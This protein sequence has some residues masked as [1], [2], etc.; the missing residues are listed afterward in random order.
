MKPDPIAH[1]K[2]I[3]NLL[4]HT[5]VTGQ[6]GKALSLEIGIASAADKILRE[7][8]K[9]MVIGN[10]GSA[11]IA[12]HLQNDLCKAVGARAMVF[13]EPPLLTALSNDHGYGCVFERPIELW[14]ESRDLLIAISCSGESENVLRGVRVAKV[15]GCEIMTFSGFQ[16]D[17]SLRRAGDLNFYISSQSYGEVEVSHMALTHFLTDYTMT[18]RPGARKVA[19]PS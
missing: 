2:K 9:I 4:I 10:G 8:G 3:S 15:K 7:E 6:D 14:A 1:F 11:A 12:S 5:E 17:N 18:V 13:N 19:A 16:S